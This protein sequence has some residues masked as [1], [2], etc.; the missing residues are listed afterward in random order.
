VRHA[1]VGAGLTGVQH[2]AVRLG[3]QQGHAGVGPAAATRADISIAPA[4]L[5]QRD[6][7]RP[8]ARQATKRPL[9]GKACRN[10]RLLDVYTIKRR[11]FMQKM[12][13]TSDV[14]SL[15]KLRLVVD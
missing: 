5:Q 14:F 1:R 15:I 13:Y 9:Y 6:P 7:G 11:T 4:V 3:Q 8:V 2:E 10:S 12:A